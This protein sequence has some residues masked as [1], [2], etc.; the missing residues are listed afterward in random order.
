MRTLALSRFDFAFTCALQNLMR[1]A[2]VGAVS[3]T[4]T[5]S[6][7]AVSSSVTLRLQRTQQGHWHCG[8]DTG[9]DARWHG[10]SGAAGAE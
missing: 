3:P 6:R 4:P 8:R 9:S 7:S 5:R 1:R 2:S 10:G